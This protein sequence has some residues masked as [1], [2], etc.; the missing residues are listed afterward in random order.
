MTEN[1]AQNLKKL[2]L[3]RVLYSVSSQ[4]FAKVGLQQFPLSAVVH[5][6]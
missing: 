4:R 1:W 5:A 6:E 3:K 2:T